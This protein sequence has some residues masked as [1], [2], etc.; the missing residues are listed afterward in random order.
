MKGQYDPEVND[1]SLVPLAAKLSDTYCDAIGMTGTSW[2]ELGEAE[3]KADL[4][5]MA[6]V[7]RMIW[8]ERADVLAKVAKISTM[9]HQIGAG[10]DARRLA[11]R[12]ANATIRAKLLS[13]EL[14]SDQI[15]G[16]A[17][18]IFELAVQ[19]LA[20][21]GVEGASITSCSMP[22]EAGQ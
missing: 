8:A 11:D 6:V 20:A 3:R 9:A 17:M 13:K 7:R 10:V 18:S 22:D 5:A 1:P 21:A 15:A 14:T 16:L 4:T 12:T 19:V 2:R